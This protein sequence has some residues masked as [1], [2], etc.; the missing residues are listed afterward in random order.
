M[1][2]PSASTASCVDAGKQPGPDRCLRAAR[3]LGTF[4]KGGRREPL[5]RRAPCPLLSRMEVPNKWPSDQRHR[6]IARFRCLCHAAV[7]LGGRLMAAPSCTPRTAA[8]VGSRSAAASAKTSGPS[9]LPRRSGAGRWALTRPAPV[10]ALSC[11]PRMAA[12]PGR[13]RRA[14]PAQS[15][16][17]S[18]LPRRAVE[19]EGGAADVGFYTLAVGD[20]RNVT[21]RKTGLR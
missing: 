18:P 5:P 2:L 13:R 19:L 10:P 9:P 14:A 20:Q 3:Q 15:C 16:V 6:R 21:E 11:T 4:V 1:G 12:V 17:P 8:A 7:G